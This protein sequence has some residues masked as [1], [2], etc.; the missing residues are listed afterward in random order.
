[1]GDKHNGHIHNY[2]TPIFSDIVVYLSK[3]TN[4]NNKIRYMLLNI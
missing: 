1:M 2:E 3:L 4:N